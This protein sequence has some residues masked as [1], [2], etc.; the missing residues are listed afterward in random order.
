VAGGAAD[1]A[2]GQA[3]ETA[4]GGSPA[5]TGD[6]GP[7]RA[8]SSS[9]G[10]RHGTS[11]RAA[12]AGRRLARRAG[13]GSDTWCAGAGP[14]RGHTGEAGPGQGRGGGAAP[15]RL[16]DGAARHTAAAGRGVRRGGGERVSERVRES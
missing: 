8:G 2:G 13:T 9:D 1:G 11:N 10:G 12:P 7:I 15:R 6:A 4:A 5:G 14:S 3:Q 16:R